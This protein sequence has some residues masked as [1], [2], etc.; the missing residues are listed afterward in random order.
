MGGFHRDIE[1]SDALLVPGDVKSG[2]TERPPRQESLDGPRGFVAFQDAGNLSAEGRVGQPGLGQK[3]GAVAKAG[4]KVV[5][6]NIGSSAGRFMVIDLGFDENQE[7]AL[8]Q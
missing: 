5:S 7:S 6:P 4:A 8:W 3:S 1:A 2:W